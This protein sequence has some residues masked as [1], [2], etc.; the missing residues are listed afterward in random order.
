MF[1]GKQR[2]TFIQQKLSTSIVLQ[3]LAEFALLLGTPAPWMKT[4]EWVTFGPSAVSGTPVQHLQNYLF[5]V[6]NRRGGRLYF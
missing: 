2:N 3:P 6:K 5:R 4:A 1:L